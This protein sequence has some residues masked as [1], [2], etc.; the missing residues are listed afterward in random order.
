MI[1]WSDLVVGRCSGSEL[2]ATRNTTQPTNS[3]VSGEPE[4]ASDIEH[5]VGH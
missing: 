2:D 3:R 1:G 4:A 5:L